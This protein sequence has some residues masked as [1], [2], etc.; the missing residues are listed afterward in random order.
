M[1][2]GNERIMRRI[3]ALQEKRAALKNRIQSELRSPMPD[4]QKLRA[5]KSKR[6][7]LKDMLA[8]YHAIRRSDHRAPA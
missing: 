7:K 3:E 5:L 4:W 1:T 8:A 2:N 6:L